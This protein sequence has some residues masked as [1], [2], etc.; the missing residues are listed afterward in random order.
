M[1]LNNHQH[2]PSILLFVN[3]T[4]RTALAIE[5]QPF[6]RGVAYLPGTRTGSLTSRCFLLITLNSW[7]RGVL[8]Q[9]PRRLPP[10]FEPH[11]LP[12]LRT[13]Y[14]RDPAACAVAVLLVL[15]LV[16]IVVHL[17]LIII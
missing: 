7:C 5:S 14:V 17:L 3:S 10:I 13:S 8:Y 9:L 16:I 6:R 2:T 15:V 1:Y 11:A 4:A 12:R